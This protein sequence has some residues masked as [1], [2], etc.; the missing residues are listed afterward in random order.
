MGFEEFI[1]WLGT[2]AA[3][4][5]VSSIMLTIIKKI[6]PTVQACLDKFKD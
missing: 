5:V 6:W 1:A 2:S 3:L 4:G